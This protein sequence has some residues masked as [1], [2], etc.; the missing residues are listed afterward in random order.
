MLA[1]MHTHS[2]FSPDADRGADIEKMALRAA[3]LGLGILTVT[4]H[5][6]LNFRFSE[7]EHAYP[8]Y[9]LCDRD[10][11][12]SLGYAL[13]S[14]EAVTALKERY[15]VLRCG[16]ELGQLVQAPDTAADLA[17]DLRL[18]F[19]IGSLHMN[20]GKPDFYWIEYNK[21]DSSELTA[22]LDAYF[23]EQLEVCRTADFDVLGHLTYPLRYIV[24]KYGIPVELTRWEG[25]IEDIFRALIGRGKGIEIN[26][27][28]LRQEYDRTFPDLGLVR[29]YRQLGGEILTLGSDAHRIEDIGSGL[30]AGAELAKQAG[31]DYM[32]VFTGRKPEFVKL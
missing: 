17:S 20:R 6:D 27:S 30:Q 16:I 26:T 10:M 1:D 25:I 13:K 21:M 18:D 7:S 5:C 11:F 3:E 2:S 24:G 23:E 32:T 14:I 15:P 22:L 4:D 9:L 19:V 29:L 12:G 8:D 31:F 28:G